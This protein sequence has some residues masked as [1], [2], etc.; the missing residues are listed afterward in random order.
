MFTKPSDPKKLQNGILKIEIVPRL[1]SRVIFTKNFES[2]H[3]FV[4][5]GL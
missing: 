5:Y 1:M 2:D 4:K 3:H